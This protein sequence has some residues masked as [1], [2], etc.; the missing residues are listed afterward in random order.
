M[1]SKMKR[2]HIPEESAY[3]TTKFKKSDRHLHKDLSEEEQ[4]KIARLDPYH[5]VIYPWTQHYSEAHSSYFFYNPKTD[6]KTWEL[7]AEI[8]KLA[9]T[10]FAQKAEKQNALLTKNLSVFLPKQELNKS[11]DFKTDWKTKPAPVQKDTRFEQE[12]AYKEGGQE[13]NIWYDKTIQDEIIP[14]REAAKNRCDPYEHCGY[15]KADTVERRQSYF[16]FHF[17]RGN[18]YLGHDCGFYH[19]IPT[20][21][22]CLEI[23]NSKDIF[24][25]SRFSTHRKDKQGIGNFMKET[26]TLKISDFCVPQGGTNRIKAAYEVLWR[27]FSL[28]GEIDDL[29]FLSSRNIAYIRYEHR[30]M[31]EFAKESMRDQTLDADEIVTIEW[32]DDDNFELGREEAD[33]LNKEVKDAQ[34]TKKKRKTIFDYQKEQDD[35]IELLN[36]KKRSVDPSKVVMESELK[37]F[38]HKL[39]RVKKGQDKLSKA[40]GKIRQRKQRQS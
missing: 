28:W 2:V 8:A 26:R 31:A 33:E 29:F 18:C 15:T 10:Y 30:C 37:L 20:L 32:C 11:Y 16:C 12:Y 24:G 3:Q 5:Q 23:D 35:Q 4:A 1:T 39:K 13:Y 25:R 9:D 38:E 22:E 14:Q 7:P 17:A 34:P 21:D 27:H 6:E 36:L 19:H 40:L